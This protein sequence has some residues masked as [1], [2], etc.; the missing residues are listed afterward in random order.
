MA[1]QTH[2]YI[3]K[4]SF[5]PADL[6]QV[7]KSL[8]EDPRFSPHSLDFDFDWIKRRIELSAESHVCAE[9]ALEELIRWVNAAA[10]TGNLLPNECKEREDG[11]FAI[12]IGVLLQSPDVYVELILRQL[13]EYG[14]RNASPEFDGDGFAIPLTNSNKS[15]GYEE[16][17]A[18]FPLPQYITVKDEGVR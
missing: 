2:Y 6:F 1:T 14:V 11:R 13:D 8:C 18:A 16:V 15:M 5:S 3:L 9:D 7:L 17:I 10:G 4:S 12:P